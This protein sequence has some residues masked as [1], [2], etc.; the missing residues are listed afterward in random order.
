M[1]FKII[2]TG[3]AYPQTCKT[4][5]DLGAFLD[6][7]DEWIFTRTGIKTRHICTEES[8]SDLSSLA[9]QRAL[10]NAATS[11][12]ELDL[13][14]CATL[15]GDYFTPSL[16]CVV[17][18]ALGATCPAFDINAA[19]TGFIYGLD[20]ADGYFARKKAKKILL[21]GAEV[22]SR[23][24]DW[25]DRSTCVLF[26]DAA[27]AAV[28]EEGGDGLLA[29]KLAAQGNTDLLKMENILGNCP[30]TPARTGRPFLQMQ[31][32]EVYKFAVS[33]M[34]RDL[35]QVIQEAGL[36]K[37][38]LDF[39]L[40]HQANIRII[41]AARHK[42]GIPAEKCPTNM[43]RFG[44]TSSASIP[45]L[46]DELHQAGAFKKGHILALAAFGG[47]LTSGACIIKWLI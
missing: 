5:Q 39:V 11:P 43:V 14:I 37:D 22:I 18:K 7:S 23:F 1:S 16:A 31:G 44:N 20:I 26:G 36:T 41:E 9:A 8:I 33:A 35:E 32:G 47:G 19:C 10:E 21:I 13:I 25:T 27:G 15:V 46:M 24:A 3:S 29:L 30:F 17:Q 38:E 34:C 45:L 6:T 2:G 12:E 4:N 28:L 42:L 40:P